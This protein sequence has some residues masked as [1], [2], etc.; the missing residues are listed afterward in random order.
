MV[1]RNTRGKTRNLNS[2]LVHKRNMILKH[3]LVFSAHLTGAV[4]FNLTS[5][6]SSFGFVMILCLFVS[7]CVP[8]QSSKDSFVHA[9]NTF[10]GDGGGRLRSSRRAKQKQV[11]CRVSRACVGGRRQNTRN[12]RYGIRKYSFWAVKLSRS[13]QSIQPAGGTHIHA[14][15]SAHHLCFRI[16]RDIELPCQLFHYVS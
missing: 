15:K 4:A 12:S 7:C 6:C 5:H 14:K 8:C 10:F 9:S 16:F 2:Y 13:I 11:W 3:H 1:S